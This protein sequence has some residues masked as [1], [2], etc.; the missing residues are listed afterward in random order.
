[1]SIENCQYYLQQALEERSKFIFKK[2]LCYKRLKNIKK[3][4]SAK[5]CVRTRSSNVHNRKGSITLHANARK[6]LLT[7][8]GA[9]Y[10]NTPVTIKTL[11]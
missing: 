4:F 9:K 6:K 11:N 3:E 10:R 1:M 7:S 2:K 5:T 8:F